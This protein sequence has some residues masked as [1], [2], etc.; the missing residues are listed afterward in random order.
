M[1]PE[2]I[3]EPRRQHDR[4]NS[5][6][7]LSRAEMSL[8][9]VGSATEEEGDDWEYEYDETE[10]EVSFATLHEATSKNNL[11]STLPRLTT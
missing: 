1:R 8:N 11:T 3:S 9:N 5:T 10:T 4:E 7:N 6:K 2:L